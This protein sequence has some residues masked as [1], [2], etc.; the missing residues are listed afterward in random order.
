MSVC[1]CV[2]DGNHRDPWGRRRDGGSAN[3]GSRSGHEGHEI[4]KYFH[5]KNPLG[6]LPCA[7][8]RIKTKFHATACKPAPCSRPPPPTSASPLS[9][10]RALYLTLASPLCT[11][12]SLPLSHSLLAPSTLHQSSADISPSGE[13]SPRTPKP[14]SPTPAPLPPSFSVTQPPQGGL[15]PALAP[16]CPP[17][18]HQHELSHHPLDCTVDLVFFRTLLSVPLHTVQP[19][20]Q[21]PCPSGPPWLPFPTI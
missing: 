8:S 1:H 9:S 20:R 7:P 11:R 10:P 12:C 19:P 21:P 6:R 16:R 18:R 15:A 3:R 14:Q 2:A 13:P 17:R 4:T 5:H